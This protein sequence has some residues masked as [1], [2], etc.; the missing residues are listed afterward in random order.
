MDKLKRKY[1]LDEKVPHVTEEEERL[2]NEGV[3]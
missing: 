1:T 2:R 3:E